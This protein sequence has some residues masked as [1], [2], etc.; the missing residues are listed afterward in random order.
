MAIRWRRDGRLVCAA[1]SEAEEGDVYIDDNLHSKL[2]VITRSI[3]ADVDHKENGLWSFVTR[4][5]LVWV[6]SR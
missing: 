2:S 6:P 1:M 3:V 5:F 4:P